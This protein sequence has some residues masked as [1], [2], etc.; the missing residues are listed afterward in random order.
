MRAALAA[1]CESIGAQT[2]PP[3]PDFDPAKYREIYSDID[4]S[5]FQPDRATEAQWQAVYRWRKA[6]NAA[7]Q[8]AP[9]PAR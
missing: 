8:P 6:M 4:I 9:K 5:G 3:N 7:V 1:W 2:N